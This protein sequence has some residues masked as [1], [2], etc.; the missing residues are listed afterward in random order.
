VN[1]SGSIKT[2]PLNA[3]YFFKKKQYIRWNIDKEEIFP[4]YP[5]NISEGWPGLLDQFTDAEISGAIYVPGWKNRIWFFFKDQTQV[6]SWDVV[7]NCVDSR[8]LPI[9]QILPSGLV[10]GGG[11]FAPIYVDRDDAQ[12][13]YAFRG[14]EYTRFT[15]NG[16]ELPDREDEGYPRKIGDGWTGGLTISPTCGVSVN[17]PNRSKALANHKLYFFLGNLYTRWD[18]ASHSNNYRLD[19]PSGWKGWPDFE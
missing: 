7:N 14:D 12:M 3:V 6:A 4:G 18:V 10:C 8:L 17:W 9:Q 1:W 2:D 5:K 13:V 19:I 16:D 11:H 15:V